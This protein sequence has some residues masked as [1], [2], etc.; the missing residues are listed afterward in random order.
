[1]RETSRH[2]RA[3]DLYWSLGPER[4]IE[5]LNAALH[6]IGNGP[7]LRTLFEWSR[8]YH[9]QDRLA[10]LERDARLAADAARLQALREM[11]ERHTKEALLLQQKGAEWISRMDDDH[12]TADAA[13]RALVE[14]VRMERLARGEPTEKHEINGE[15]EIRPQLKEFSDEQLD[16]LI[17]L[18]ER[19]VARIPPPESG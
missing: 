10:Q 12:V 4:T 15:L 3:F 2:Q 1:M 17:D 5:R 16:D 6:A 11:A 7:S 18:V 14:G 9:W 8:Q 13:I 19:G